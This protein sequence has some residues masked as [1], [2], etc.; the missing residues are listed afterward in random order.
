MKNVLLFAFVERSGVRSIYCLRIFFEVNLLTLHVVAGNVVYPSKVDLGQRLCDPR[1][2]LAQ[3]EKG[4]RK[5]FKPHIVCVS[6]SSELNQKC[7]TFSPCTVV[8]SVGVYS[9]IRPQLLLFIQDAGGEVAIFI[10]RDLFRTFNL[11]LSLCLTPYTDL[12]GVNISL[13]KL[14]LTSMFFLFAP[15][16]GVVEPAPF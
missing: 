6:S 14:F 15:L 1:T 5:S 13:K 4:I 9:G 10:R 11:L 12:A 3:S 16:F 2:H 7:K 8:L